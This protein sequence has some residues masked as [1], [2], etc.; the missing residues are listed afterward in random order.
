MSSD[1]HNGCGENLLVRLLRQPRHRQICSSGS[2][3]VARALTDD[4]GERRRQGHHFNLVTLVASAAPRCMADARPCSAA[5]RL[6]RIH[7]SEPTC[8]LTIKYV[9]LRLN[10]KTLL[11]S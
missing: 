8:L 11:H 9:V 7:I 2:W 1:N 10:K 3:E 4:L 5:Q 6:P